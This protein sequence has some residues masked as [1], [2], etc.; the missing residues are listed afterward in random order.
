MRR[1]SEELRLLTSRRVKVWCQLNCNGDGGISVSIDVDTG[2][3]RY[4]L[5][6]P[7]SFFLSRRLFMATRYMGVFSFH[8]NYAE[9]IVMVIS[10]FIIFY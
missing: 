4:S 8:V 3:D 1:A 6:I 9:D 5:V 10:Q 7:C 2:I